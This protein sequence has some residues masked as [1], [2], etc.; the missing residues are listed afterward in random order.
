MTK[1][2]RRIRQSLI[3][4]KNISKYLIYAIGEI[5]LVVIGILI[6]L[7]INN[8]NEQKKFEKKE[9]AFLNRLLV[10]LENDKDYLEIVHSRKDNKV[11]AANTIIKFSFVGNNDSIM[12]IIPAYLQ[13]TSWQTI[14][15][16]QNTFNELISS[17]SLNILRNDSIKNSLLQLDRNFQALI[18]WEEVVKQDDYIG[19]FGPIA[20]SW[21]LIIIYRSIDL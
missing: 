17:G 20:M 11:K 8:W 18:D 5:V 4:E 16:N 15:P 3:S 12:K 1:I 6:A 14:I 19:N 2:F 7:Q 9:F 13:L 10:D 21:I